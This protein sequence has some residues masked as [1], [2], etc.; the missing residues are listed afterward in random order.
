MGDH[1]N[2][3]THMVH[4]YYV[5]RVREAR[6]KR[7]AQR[8]TVKTR[9][10]AI[11][12]Q[13]DVRAKIKRSFGPF[14]KRT[15]LDVHTTGVIDRPSY[16]IEKLIYQSRP[17]FLVTASLYVPKR[18]TAPAPCVLGTCGH[19]PRAKAAPFYQ[20]FSQGLARKGFVVLIYDPISQGERPQYPNRDKRCRLR[21]CPE[22]NMLGNQQALVGEFFGMWRAWDGIRGLDYLLSRP[23]VD[24]HRVGLTGNSGGGTMTTWLAGLDD[25]FTMAAPGCFVTTLL[26]NMENELPG[27]VEQIPPRLLEFGLDEFELFIPHAPKP[28]ILLT[29]GK[30]FFDPRGAQQAYREL[31]KLYRLLGAEQNVR[32]VTGPTTHGYTKELREAMYGFFG[33]HAGLRV[34]AKEPRIRIEEEETLR[35]TRSGLVIRHGSKKVIDFTREKADALARQRGRVPAKKL[36]TVLK[37]ALVLPRRVGPPHHRVLTGFHLGKTLCQNFSLDTEPG[38]QAI[39][40]MPN[41]EGWRLPAPAGKRCNVLVPHLG[42]ADDLRRASVRKVL[43]KTR[44]FAVDPRGIGQSMSV[45]CMFKDFFTP[46]D[47][48]YF[49]HAYALMLGKPYLGRR[50]HDVLST[51]DWVAL[52]GYEDVHVVGRGMGAVLALLA[53]AIDDRPRKVTLVNGLLSFHEL[54]QVPIYRWPASTM[55]KGVLGKFDLPDCYRALRKKIKVL[56][57]WDH[58]MKPLKPAEARRR[59]RS[60]GL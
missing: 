37:R 27:D 24:R 15:P 10:D 33:R 44:T 58:R 38:I 9:A 49:Y 34:S 26:S 55:L 31:K 16:T 43:G 13:K 50:V 2:R 41:P 48:D 14:P 18:L 21:L 12:L 8:A 51:L 11:R 40:T 22:H 36:K 7:L 60:M 1:F 25:R 35:A 3:Y 42:A 29:Q 23:E 30:D 20:S 17:G 6:E 46:Y 54:T 57:P 5:A 52:L 56:Q 32:I 39:V 19:S 45:S 59:L 28:L 53:C 4:E 47:S